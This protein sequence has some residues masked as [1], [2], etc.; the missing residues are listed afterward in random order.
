MSDPESPLEMIFIGAKLRADSAHPVD[1]HCYITMLRVVID[2][3]C[4][5]SIGLRFTALVKSQIHFSD[6]AK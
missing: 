1:M 5:S 2:V 6:H 4:S 3:H